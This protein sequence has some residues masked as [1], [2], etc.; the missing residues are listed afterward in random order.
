MHGV[1]EEFADGK[2]VTPYPFPRIPYREAIAQ[3]RHRQAGPAQPAGDAGR[4]RAFPRRRLRR[5]R[6]ACWR[7]AEGARSGRSRR[8]AAASRAFCDR[9]NGW[10]QGEGQPGLGYIFWREG[11]EGGAG[12][13]R[14]RTSAPS[15]PRR[16]ARS[17]AWRSATRSSSSP[18]IRTPSTSSPALARTKVGDRAG[19]DRRR[20]GSSSAGSST[21]RCTSGT[22]T[23]SK[24]DFSHN[25]FSMPQG[26][27]GG[28][29][30]TQG[31]AAISWPTSTTSSATAWSC[32][33]ARSGTTGPR[34]CSRPS[35]SPAIGPEVVER[36][37][38]RHAQRLPLSARR[39]TAASRRAS[40]A[41][42]CCWPAPT[43]IRDVIAFPLNQQAQDLMMNAPSRGVGDKQL[44]EL[45]IR[46]K[47]AEEGLA[48]LR[49]P[50]QAKREPGSQKVKR[51]ILLRS[52][53]RLRRSGMTAAAI[54]WLTD[55]TC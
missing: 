25:P 12:P 30:A 36:E 33:P 8:R 49:H 55:K 29:E 51:I 21:S 37:V 24:I 38:R 46:L 10:A 2:P 47:S 32:P 4:L 22:R 41:S 11:E 14:A 43:N 44:R 18:A 19:P 27:H 48:S 16:S 39:R 45:H 31:P 7:R 28:A 34:S 53:I 5:V 6:A 9:M 23:T 15:G 3:V 26:E 40:T 20:T 54:H 13:D 17:W 1:F 52:R 50:G 35:R 42:S